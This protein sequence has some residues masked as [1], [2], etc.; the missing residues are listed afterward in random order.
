MIAF[1]AWAFPWRAPAVAK[2]VAFVPNF[3]SVSR[4]LHTATLGPYS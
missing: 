1:A 4:I 3:A 2:K